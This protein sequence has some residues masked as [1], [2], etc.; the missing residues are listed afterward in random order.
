MAVTINDVASQAGVSKSTVSCYL[1]GRFESMSPETRERIA[2]VIADLDFRPN[3]LAR[4]LKQ[5][6]THTIAVI[7]ANILNPFSTAVIRGAEDYCKKSGMNLI[8]CNADEDAAKEK[9]YI[10]ML[11]AKQVD[12]LIINTTGCNNQ[13]I[14]EVNAATPIVLIDRKVPE[15]QCDTVTVDGI[16]GSLQAANHLFALGHRRIAMFTLPYRNVSPREERVRGFKQALELHGL[17]GEPFLLIETEAE[18]DAVARRIEELLRRPA[19]PTAIFGANNLITMAVI[20]A[21]KKLGLAMPDDVA[22]IGFDDWEWA[23][24]IDPPVTV[25]A[26]PAYQ[27]GEKAASILIKRIKAGKPPKK[28]A[29]VVYEPQLIV[30]KSCGEA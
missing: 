30:R 2:A 22:V 26:Q 15:I 12:G 10:E 6:R 17:A 16:H 8:L 14:K 4:S 13:F 19:R 18:E 27:M 11:L 28:P 23:P 21:L 3:A 24:L 5:K 1:N 25:V 9:E 29:L 7:V 20:K